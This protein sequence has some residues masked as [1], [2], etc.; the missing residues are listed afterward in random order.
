MSNKESERA[1]IHTVQKV[2]GH[3]NNYGD[4]DL[5]EGPVIMIERRF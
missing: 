3:Q 1:I 2:S 4:G 5:F